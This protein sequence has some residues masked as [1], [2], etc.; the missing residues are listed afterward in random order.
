MVLHMSTTVNFWLFHLSKPINHE[1]F[2]C[3]HQWIKLENTEG[4]FANEQFREIGNIGHTRRRKT[5]QK[6]NTICVGHHYTQTNTNDVNNTRALLQTTG[7]KD[8]PNFVF[9]IIWFF[10]YK[11]KWLMGPSHIPSRYTSTIKTKLI[12]YHSALLQYKFK[13]FAI[14]KKNINRIK[15]YL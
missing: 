1:Y 5:N 11:P 10:I 2:I 4:A 9:F 6:H 7:G 12:V 8:E 15:R 14:R 3:H 13:T